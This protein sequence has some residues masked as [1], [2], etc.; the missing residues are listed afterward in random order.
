MVKSYG[1]Y[2]FKSFRNQVKFDTLLDDNIDFLTENTKENLLKGLLFVGPNA[3]GKTN[4]LSL[5]QIILEIVFDDCDISNY[6]NIFNTGDVGM[7]YTFLINNKEVSYSINFHHKNNYIDEQLSIDNEEVYKR[8][9]MV[10]HN[11]TGVE[12]VEATLP[13]LKDVLKAECDKGNRTLSGFYSFLKESVVVDLYS[14]KDKGANINLNPKM[15]YNDAMIKEINNFLQLHNFEFTIEKQDK[16]S[17]IEGLFF[18]RSN[19]KI[20]MP[21]EM[22]SIGNKTLLY[23]FPILQKMCKNSGMLILDEFGSGMHNELEELLIRYFFLQKGKSQ[24]FMVSH[25]TNLLTNTLFRPDQIYSV[26]FI[27]GCSVVDKFSS[28][29][30]RSTQNLEKM[31]LG[32]VFGGLPKYTKQ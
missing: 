16:D 30:P 15:R 26:D 32:G 24:I 28:E 12:V 25:S 1:G 10:V 19:S 18:K 13:I 8:S 14:K 2:N 4:A 20:K 29:S 31:Y 3:S 9:N 11:Y 6:M 17:Y 23:I 7:D 5:L 21:F 27:N 22:E